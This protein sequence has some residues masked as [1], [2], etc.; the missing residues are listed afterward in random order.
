MDL[1]DYRKRLDEIDDDILKLFI[2]RMDIAAGIGTWK[3]E[4]NFPVLDVRRE[5]EKLQKIED[6]S[7]PEISDYS[8]TLFS[9]IMELSRSRQNRILISICFFRIVSF[10][11]DSQADMRI[12]VFI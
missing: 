4:N 9:T 1:S 10:H 3:Q 6:M 7:P 5:R 8:F 12:T 11:G 2:E